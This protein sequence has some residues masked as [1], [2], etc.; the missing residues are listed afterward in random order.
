[1]GM[2]REY[3]TFEGNGSFYTFILGPNEEK[4]N[5]YKYKLEQRYTSI[6]TYI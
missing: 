5:L 6:Y 2:N 1:M 4:K 3:E